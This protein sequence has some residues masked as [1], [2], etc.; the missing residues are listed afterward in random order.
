MGEISN[1]KELNRENFTSKYSP[2]VFDELQLQEIKMGIKSGVDVDTYADPSFFFLQM[3]EIRLGLE[4]G[5]DILEYADVDYDWYQMEEIRVGLE[6]NLDVSIY[7]KEEYS[8]L[9]MREIRK[10][11]EQGINLLPFVERKFGNSI[12]KQIRHANKCGIIIEKYVM[13]GFNSDQLEQI[14]KGIRDNV[15]IET[16]LDHNLLGSQMKEIRLGLKKNL[17]VSNYSDRKYNWMQM[18]E[19]RLG[20][21]DRL[22]V[23]WYADAFFSNKQMEEIRLGL[24][25]GIDI[26]E[27]ATYMWSATDMRKKRLMQL[28]GIKKREPVV[29]ATEDTVDYANGLNCMI[30]VNDSQMEAVIRLK[31]P[32]EG[33]YTREQI[34]EGLS[35]EGVVQGILEDVL[36]DMLEHER[37]GE[38][39]V[40][41]KGKHKADG[42]DGYY[43]YFFKTE[44]PRLPK[45]L[46]DDSVDYQN[47]E[48]FET[49]DKGQKLAVYHPATTGQYGYDVRGNLVMPVRG[50][51]KAKLRIHGVE[52]LDDEVTYISGMDGRVEL[53]GDEISVYPVFTY[54]GD[55]TT[56]VGNIRFNGDIHVTGYV[57]S[58]VIIEATGD[59]VIDG[60]VEGAR[61]KAG[62]SVLVRSGVSA[63]NR[64]SIQAGDNING[65]YFEKAKL[66]AGR[67]IESNYLLNCEAIAMGKVIISGKKGSI[68]GG[69]TSAIAGVEASV[70]GNPV[71]L[72]TIFEIGENDYYR[73]K[74]RGFKANIDERAKELELLLR[75]IK[76]Y[77][78]TR[79]VEELKELKMYQ[80]L[81]IA[82][83]IKKKEYDQARDD[84]DQYE[85]QKNKRI[86]AVLVGATAFPG[87]VIKIDDAMTIVSKKVQR[88]VFRKKGKSV[89]MYS[90]R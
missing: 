3:K 69:V 73:Q 50:K 85:E 24:K 46:E 61:I 31:R 17:D 84:L 30:E 56:S 20:L 66:Y 7:A 82:L 38:D 68:S 6:H 41:A 15:D 75:E 14:W 87:C 88:I 53:L 67:N 72:K 9:L 81:E 25:D 52:I 58:G 10:G 35:K 54:R 8:F 21:E 33:S 59:V 57:G 42:K 76:K 19:I 40:I 12:L 55:V 18:R 51:D 78:M 44:I 89:A 71:E 16:Y 90:L 63:A 26:F 49:V 43:E 62:K 28:A 64:G 22:N 39:I 79:S 47:V 86:I 27:Y 4:H 11:L 77:Q 74:I 48:F 32:F 60:N 70:I 5:I 23:I 36:E 29:K 37:Y 65:K 34:M 83:M 80:N 13:D 1:A 2:E 45:V